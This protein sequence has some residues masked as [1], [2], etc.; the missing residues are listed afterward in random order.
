VKYTPQ[1][2]VFHAITRIGITSDN[3]VV[4]VV[5]LLLLYRYKAKKH[6]S[7]HNKLTSFRNMTISDEMMEPMTDKQVLGEMGSNAMEWIGEV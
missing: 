3:T 6:L 2:F 7:W 4:V 1:L 5:A